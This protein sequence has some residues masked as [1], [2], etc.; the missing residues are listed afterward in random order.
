MTDDQNPEAIQPIRR[1]HFSK[2][3]GHRN[4]LRRVGGAT[5]PRK[6][7]L[8]PNPPTA[9]TPPPAASEPT[10]SHRFWVIPDRSP[11]TIPLVLPT[12]RAADSLTAPRAVQNSYNPHSVALQADAPYLVAPE[13]ALERTIVSGDAAAL[14]SLPFQDAAARWLESRRAVLRDRTF[15]MYGHHLHTL[16]KFF[17]STRVKDI[18]IGHVIAYQL[19][20]MENQEDRWTQKAG[21]SVINHELSVV[22]QLMKRAGEWGRIGDFYRPLRLPALQRRRVLDEAEEQRFFAV[23]ATRTDWELAALVAKISGNTSACGSELRHL[24]FKDVILDA[25]PPRMVVN[26]D[27]AKNA[28]RG[29][30]IPLVANGVRADIELCMER[31]RKLGSGLPEHYIFPFRTV[32]N[33][34][35]PTRPTST[36]WLRHSFKSLREAAGFPWLTPHCFRHQFITTML[37]KGAAPETVRHLVGHVSE[38]MM[39]HYSHNRLGASA[40]ALK[41]LNKVAPKAEKPIAPARAQ[42]QRFMAR[43][44]RHLVMRRPTA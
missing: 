35:D 8:T 23:A 2:P 4:T 26:A 19:A 44:R 15:Y 12:T 39:R 22:Q 11:A 38:E 14:A 24:R 31:A 36:S 3:Y 41:I 42:Q 29:R 6:R 34:Y 30:V 40:E 5:Y 32:R 7:L 9:A 33:C 18:H 37:E 10:S 43:G 1:H 28:Y 27:T 17:G 21:P 20:R 16:D 25:D 13:T